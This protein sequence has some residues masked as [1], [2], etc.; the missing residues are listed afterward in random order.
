LW[1]K[2]VGNELVVAFQIMAA[3]IKENCPVGAMGV[4]ADDID[5][6]EMTLVYKKSPHHPPMI[7]S[8]SLEFHQ[9]AKLGAVSNA[10][11]DYHE[12]YGWFPKLHCA[13]SAFKATDNVCPLNRS[14]IGWSQTKILLE[15]LDT[16][17]G[18]NVVWID[19]AAFVRSSAP[20]LPD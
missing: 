13:L 5:R 6:Q 2:I 3:D 20:C 18:R 11:Y 1:E 10:L 8:T 19:F 17:V 15:H 4:P 7:S 12:L 9:P 16:T 14:P